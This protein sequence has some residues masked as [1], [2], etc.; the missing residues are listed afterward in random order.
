MNSS[1]KKEWKFVKPCSV[2]CYKCKPPLTIR[3]HG[4]FVTK[5]FISMTNILINASLESISFITLSIWWE[6]SRVYN[7][8]WMYVDICLISLPP[9]RMFHRSRCLFTIVSAMPST[10]MV[11]GQKLSL[12][13]TH[14]YVHIC[15]LYICCIKEWILSTNIKCVLCVGYCYIYSNIRPTNHSSHELPF[16]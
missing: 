12:S 13:H 16:K 2:S 11:S 6:Y 4:I 7:Y 9:K 10:V 3:F 5:S 1:Y 15:T 8:L 14:T